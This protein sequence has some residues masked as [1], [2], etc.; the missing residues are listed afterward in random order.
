[1]HIYFILG[2]LVN[3]NDGEYALTC[4]FNIKMEDGWYYLPE[5]YTDGVGPFKCREEAQNEGKKYLNE[6]NEGMENLM[7]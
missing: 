7:D 5:G 2:G 3:G 4:G 6:I 1:M